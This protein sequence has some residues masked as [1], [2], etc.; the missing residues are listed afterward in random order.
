MRRMSELTI[1]I[2]SVQVLCSVHR[3]FLRGERLLLE[4]RSLYGDEVLVYVVCILRYFCLSFMKQRTTNFRHRQIVND[5]QT[6]TQED[7]KRK[8]QPYPGQAHNILNSHNYAKLYTSMS[9]HEL[10]TNKSNQ[11]HSSFII[12]RKRETL[13]N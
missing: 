8:E 10:P 6:T 4:C 12:I 3:D 7:R 9:S 1:R 2:S 13:T 11:T 5:I